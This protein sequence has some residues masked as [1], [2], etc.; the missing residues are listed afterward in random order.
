[1]KLR[2]LWVPVA[3]SLAIACGAGEEPGDVAPGLAGLLPD[4]TTLPGWRIADGPV[5]YDPVSLYEYLNG[6]APLYLDFGFEELVHVR[7]RLGDDDLS[8]V[9]LDIFDMG[10]ELG[11]FGLCRSGRPADAE[12]RDWGAEGYRSGAVAAAWKGTPARRPAATH[13]RYCPR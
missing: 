13:P 8:S 2:T 9:T 3:I 10:S 1:M 5:V 4:E 6:G 7:Y 11:A 12:V